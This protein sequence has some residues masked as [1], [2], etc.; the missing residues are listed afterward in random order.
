MRFIPRRRR[1]R[2]PGSPAGRFGARWIVAALGLVV[3]A[4]ALIGAAGPFQ[5]TQE[6]RAAVQCDR[7]RDDCFGNEA[8]SVVARRTY[9]TTSSTTDANGHTST[10]STTHYEV[11]WR[12]ADGTEHARDVSPEFY[13]KAEEGQPANLRIWRGD[14]VGLEVMGASQWFLPESGRAL[15]Y[16]LFLA[17][18]GLGVLLWG[19]IFGW[20]DGFFMLAFRLFAWMFLSFMPVGLITDALTYGLEPGLGLVVRIVFAVVFTAVAGAMLIGSLRE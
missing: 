1:P 19:L 7:G 12:R 3:L 16:W 10:T 6:F 11:T 18:F 2:H 17:H 13:D 5:Q 8:G 14:V 9:T 4:V 20:W 15:G